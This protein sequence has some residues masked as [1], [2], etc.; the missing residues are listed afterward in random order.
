MMS[1]ATLSQY[2]LE[3][4]PPS[5]LIVGAR[6]VISYL[7]FAPAGVREAMPSSWVTCQPD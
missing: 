3:F 4:T 7:R 1:V 5:T 6:T 2:L